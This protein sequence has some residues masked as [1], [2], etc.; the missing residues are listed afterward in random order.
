MSKRYGM[1]I[2][3]DGKPISMSELK[4][5]KAAREAAEARSAS[6]ESVASSVSARSS[7]SPSPEHLTRGEA[8]VKGIKTESQKGAQKAAREAEK[9]RA[10]SLRSPSPESSTSRH[11]RTEAEKRA[12]EA[13]VEAAHAMWA[14]STAKYEEAQRAADEARVA[15][16]HAKW[17][18]STAAHEASEIEKAARRMYE[19]SVVEYAMSQPKHPVRSSSPARRNAKNLG[20]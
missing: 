6:P 15:K 2:G 8:P 11:E 18:S 14:S 9:L 7:R 3:P 4:A 20:I 17:L 1:P 5:Q 19:N 12:D 10:K 16:A 13:R